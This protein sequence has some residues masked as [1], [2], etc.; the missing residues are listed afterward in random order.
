MFLEIGFWGDFFTIHIYI[1][2][3]ILSLKLSNLT[4]SNFSTERQRWHFYYK[5]GL[6]Y[7]IMFKWQSFILKKK[8]L[9]KLKY[10]ST[11]QV[12]DIYFWIVSNMYKGS[13]NT[14]FQK[15]KNKIP[16]NQ[17][18]MAFHVGNIVKT[19]YF[20]VIGRYSYSV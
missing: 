12:G 3:I 7:N 6:V 4:E 14:I 8:T 13:N 19:F 10:I 16:Y 15:S 11:F 17:N 2:I 18:I 5:N 20:K 9:K 1:Y